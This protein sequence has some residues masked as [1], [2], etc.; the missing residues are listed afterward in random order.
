MGWYN[1]VPWGE[2]RYTVDLVESKKSGR[3]E[4][5][6]QSFNSN[7]KKKMVSGAA[8]FICLKILP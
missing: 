5:S 7:M 8:E 3:I 4:N 2:S 6:L 1:S